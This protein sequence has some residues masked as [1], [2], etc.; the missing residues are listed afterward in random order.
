MKI[1]V[2]M[3]SGRDIV[4]EDKSY[5]DYQKI[6]DYMKESKYADVNCATFEMR[7][8]QQIINFKA[9]EI[10]LIIYSN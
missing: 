5:D 8:G 7:S 9:E 1:T 4:L 10:E 2:M 6:K 3:K